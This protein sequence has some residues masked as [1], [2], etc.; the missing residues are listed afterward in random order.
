M[1][2]GWIELD[3]C[4]FRVKDRFKRPDTTS[5]QGHTYVRRTFRSF[6]GMLPEIVAVASEVCSFRRGALICKTNDDTS[7]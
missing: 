2:L 6:G 5:G 7:K 1:G 3:L 4:Q